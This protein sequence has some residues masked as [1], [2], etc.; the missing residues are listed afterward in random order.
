MGQEKFQQISTEEYVNSHINRVQKWI[1]KFSTILFIR[2]INHDKSKLCEPELSL[3]KKM[4]EEPRYPY[5]TSK[6]KEKLN[7]YKE[8]FQQHYKHNKHHPEHWSGYYCDMDLMDVIEMLCDWLGYKDDITLKEAEILVNQ[9]C[10]R[11]GF[12]EEKLDQKIESLSGGEKNMLQ[13]AKI[14]DSNAQ[15][16]LLD[17]PTSH[18][19]TYSQIALERAI[20]NFNGAVLMISH[21]FYSIV[22]CMD[23]VLIIE[24]KTI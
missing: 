19:D 20:K 4:D 11:Y 16:L 8:V 17:E 21:D 23:Y 6:Y 2:G 13:L 10:E 15:M 3:W 18:L 22:N 24:D 7:R 1:G 9:Q 14:S 5:G 12:N